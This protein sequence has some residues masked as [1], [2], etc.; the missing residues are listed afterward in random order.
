[1]ILLN[2]NYIITECYLDSGII[3]FLFQLKEGAVNKKNGK[4]NAFNVLKNKSY[5]TSKCILI[6]DYDKNNQGLDKNIS[7]QFNEVVDII[8]EKTKYHF[9]GLKSQI[10]KDGY[11]KIIYFCNEAED[12]L[13]YCLN[14]V[15]DDIVNYY[16][17]FNKEH[18]ITINLNKGIMDFS[19]KEF[20]RSSK[21]LKKIIRKL[22]DD[23]CEPLKILKEEIEN[24]F[25]K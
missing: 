19:K 16:P 13:K 11:H 2:P 4:S 10:S 23:D 22:L 14:F 17:Q 24:H 9:C 18:N 7:N 20:V 1:M 3:E 6:V 15:N 5:Q 21:V 25:N 12:F 8:G